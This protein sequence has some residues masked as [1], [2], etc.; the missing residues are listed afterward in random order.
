MNRM[1]NDQKFPDLNLKR[2]LQKLVIMICA[3]FSSLLGLLT[4]IKVVGM[5]PAHRPLTLD[6]GTVLESVP[7]L[8]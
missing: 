4:K 2:C 1:I 3:G 5:M 8:I 7:L 6:A